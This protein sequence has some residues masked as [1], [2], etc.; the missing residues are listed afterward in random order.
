MSDEQ[1]RRQQHQ[2]IHRL[3]EGFPETVDGYAV[4]MRH[5]FTGTA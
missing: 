3:A 2:K 1:Q 5:D 4:E